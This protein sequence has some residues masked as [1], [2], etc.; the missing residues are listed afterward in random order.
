MEDVPCKDCI[1]LPVCINEVDIKHGGPL[2]YNLYRY[3]YNF[4]FDDSML[5]KK[6]SLIS[7]YSTGYKH[8]FIKKFY[9]Q[10][11]GLIKEGE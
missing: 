5:I 8:E 10:K 11:K 2:V 3:T 1:C 7:E 9:L 6:C 4:I